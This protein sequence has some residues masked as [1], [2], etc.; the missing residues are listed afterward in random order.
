[1][2]H[3]GRDLGRAVALVQVDA[4][5]VHD[6][7]N[8]VNRADGG[9]ELVAAYGAGLLGEPVDVMVVDAA[10]GL[11][12]LSKV[13]KARPQHDG[14]G[15]LDGRLAALDSVF[16]NHADTFFLEEARKHAVSLGQTSRICTIVN[17]SDPARGA[18]CLQNRKW[19]PA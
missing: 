19:R 15:M 12:Q 18:L 17:D 2:A 4:P 7:G 9:L 6:H 11:N 10:D 14:D 13:T 16:R 3:E 1:M 5:G 8:I